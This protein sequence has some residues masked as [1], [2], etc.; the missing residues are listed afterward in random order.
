MLTGR[1]NSQSA[2]ASPKGFCLSLC[3][4]AVT[5][6]SRGDLGASPL[7]EDGREAR[8]IRAGFRGGLGG[9]K[10]EK[11][12][13][14]LTKALTLTALCLRWLSTCGSGARAVGRESAL[15]VEGRLKRKSLRLPEV[16]WLRR[17]PGPPEFLGGGRGGR[18][19]LGPGC[20][21]CGNRGK[22]GLDGIASLWL[23]ARDAVV[24]FARRRRG[25]SCS[26]CE[27][28]GCFLRCVGVGQASMTRG[29]RRGKAKVKPERDCNS[30]RQA[31]WNLWC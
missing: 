18:G 22:G 24:L 6:C 19:V 2:A 21:V 5:T 15:A 16:E 20:W 13:L 3:S 27:R 7:V 17:S 28:V 23:S 26:D 8:L 12:G 9:A 1:R 31:H 11:G 14:T 10:G 30:G 4:S 25:I 29:G